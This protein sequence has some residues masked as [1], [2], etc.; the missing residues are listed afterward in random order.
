MRRREFITLVGG[1]ATA[2]PLAA[3]AQ[4]K[5]MP[6]VGILAGGTSG[7]FAP[8]VAAVRQGLGEGGYVEGRNIAIEYRWAEHQD[9]RLPAL[10]ADLARRQVTVIATVGS[11]LAALAAK[12][13]TT[14]IPMVFYGAFDPVAVGLVASLARPGGN[15]TGVT[16]LGVE[17]GP[18]RLEL[19]RELL[20][21]STVMALVVNPTSRLAEIQARELQATARSLGLELH[22]QHARTGRDIVAVIA[23]LGQ[24]RAGALILGNDGFFY[25][26]REQIA[27]LA[28]HFGVPTIA[29]WRD[30]VTVG[31]LLSYGGDLVDAH[32]QVGIY[33]ARILK[34][35]KPADLPVQ[36]ATKVQLI[37]NLKTANALGLTFPLPL[38]GRADE[39]IE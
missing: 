29:P 32:R 36:L 8:L 27:A 1:A 15:V 37:I 4:Q 28:E 7:G 20:P 11:T 31:G 25:S 30:F 9:D 24:L 10:A 2:W 13:V 5:A 23:K 33:T 39:V 6:V 21:N 35:D 22:V 26:Q 34:G 38:L 3:R 16:S 18:K 19:L 14:T 12:A 17:V